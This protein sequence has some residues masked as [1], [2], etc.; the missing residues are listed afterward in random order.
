MAIELYLN[1][2]IIVR[3]LNAGHESLRFGG[4]GKGHTYD[5]K[6]GVEVLK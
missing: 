2:D 1:T 3:S 5:V 4:W 6:R